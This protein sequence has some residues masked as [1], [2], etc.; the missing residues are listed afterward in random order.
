MCLLFVCAIWRQYNAGVRSVK[1]WR[2][3][4]I[5]YILLLSL[6]LPSRVRLSFMVLIIICPLNLVIYLYTFYNIY[7]YE[8]LKNNFKLYVPINC[9]L[10]HHHQSTF[11]N[12]LELNQNMTLMIRINYLFTTYN[13]EI[14]FIN[15]IIAFTFYILLFFPINKCIKIS[16]K[17][18]TIISIIEH[19]ICNNYK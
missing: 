1:G 13:C 7:F 9:V 16:M 11:E 17:H 3:W 15:S 12:C 19:M 18:H 8:L 4:W 6:N 10:K 14:E 2:E 5:Q